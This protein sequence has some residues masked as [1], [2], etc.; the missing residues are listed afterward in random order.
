MRHSVGELRPVVGFKQI[1]IGL[2]VEIAL[3]PET[4]IDAYESAP[5]RS[6]THGVDVDRHAEVMFKCGCLEVVDHHR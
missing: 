3:Q 1:G 6:E 4:S 5:F 2:P